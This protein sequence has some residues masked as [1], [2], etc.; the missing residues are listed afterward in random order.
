MH[1]ARRLTLVREVV[2]VV[3]FWIMLGL[4]IGLVAWAA[5]RQKRY[6]GTASFDRDT[7]EGERWHHSEY[8][9]WGLGR[10]A[11]NEDPERH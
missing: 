1:P 4:L 2:A 7:L 5:W 6:A 11:G 9:P 10:Q 3:V 8:H